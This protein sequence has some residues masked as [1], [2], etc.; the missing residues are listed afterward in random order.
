MQANSFRVLFLIMHSTPIPSMLD[1]N[2]ICG[3]ENG[4]G[5]EIQMHFQLF[6]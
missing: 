1:L 5:R 6:T 4:V 2:K 3:A